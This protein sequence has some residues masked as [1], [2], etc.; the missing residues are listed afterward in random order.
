MSVILGLLLAYV[1]GLE[2]NLPNNCHEDL[3]F[4]SIGDFNITRDNFNKLIKRERYLL[5][6]LTSPYCENCCPYEA[7]IKDLRD[8]HFKNSTS[9]LYKKNVLIGRIDV[10]EEK[11]F[12]ELHPTLKE[13]PGWIMYIRG[14]PFYLQ[15]TAFINRLLNTVRQLVE[16]YQEIVSLR[17]FEDL[18]AYTKKDIS[19]RHMI[20]NKVLGLFA[21]SDDYDGIVDNFKDTALRTYWREDTL[22]G[23]CT[24]PAVVKEIFGKFGTKYVPNQYDKNTIF[25]LKGKNRFAHSDLL[26]HYDIAKPIDLSK[27]LARSSISPLEEMT[28]LNQMSFTTAAPMIIAFV[29]P[30]QESKT[31]AFLDDLSNLGTKYLNRVNFVW[32]D[33]KDNLI[34]MQK[35]GIEGVKI[36]CVGLS[37]TDTHRGVFVLDRD[38][39]VKNI[40]KFVDGFFENSIS[41]LD[42]SREVQENKERSESKSK[43]LSSTKNLEYLDFY[44]Y[45]QDPNID[46]VVMLYNSSEPVT[47]EFARRS[48]IFG[49]LARG[50]RD[51]LGLHSLLMATY[52]IS[53]VRLDKGFTDHGN[54]E[55]DTIYFIPATQNKGPFSRL[56]T[57]SFTARDI[58]YQIHQLQQDKSDTSV[59]DYA[60]NIDALMIDERANYDSRA[61]DL[62]L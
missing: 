15:Q 61:S 62:D 5:I 47:E 8:N 42:R 35:L 55:S 18:L 4:K 51:E 12:T 41:H 39:T 32:V 6:Q 52:D 54:F 60:E 14:E 57:G 29:D 13:L 45:L 20:R 46:I 1:T 48:E 24:K 37:G 16:P 21:D 26:K 44:A 28:S 56:D 17:Q 50:F 25:L 11:W 22:Y 31:Q 2:Q 10:S 30:V 3:P 36:P 58:A 38:H 40:E 9:G 27:W 34:L 33:Y 49:R 7:V 23:L 53:K 59:I 43:L 19:G